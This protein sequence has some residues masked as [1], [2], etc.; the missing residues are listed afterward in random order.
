[1]VIGS[2]AIA[3]LMTFLT[4]SELPTCARVFMIAPCPYTVPSSSPG[5]N[6]GQKVNG[7]GAEKFAGPD[8]PVPPCDSDAA[9]LCFLTDRTRESVRREAANWPLDAN[10]GSERP[11]PYDD[12]V[13]VL[14]ESTCTSS[15]TAAKGDRRRRTRRM[16][17]EVLGDPSALEPVSQRGSA[18]ALT[19]AC[20][21]V[22]V[23]ELRPSVSVRRRWFI[24][25]GWEVRRCRKEW[26]GWAAA[27]QV[28]EAIRVVS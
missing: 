21:A 2:P 19:G 18:V 11:L 24:G 10:P 28:V 17:R 12:A 13:L 14:D 27:S 5:P 15:S 26:A 8:P 6:V 9:V 4:L 7:G 23:P 20:L 3:R 22:R 25:G 16:E 1:M